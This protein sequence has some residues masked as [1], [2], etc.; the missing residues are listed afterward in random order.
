MVW[1]KAAYLLLLVM[2]A[3]LPRTDQPSA[4]H[5]IVIVLFLVV[6][7]FNLAVFH[8][9]V[10]PITSYYIKA[11]HMGTSWGIIGSSLGLCQCTFSLINMWV[12]SSSASALK[13]YSKLT[14]LFVVMAILSLGIAFWIRWRDTYDS[15]DRPFVENENDHSSDLE[16]LP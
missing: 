13:A 6:F 15:L 3:I 2:V 9:I 4:M 7:S 11:E 14:V 1:S 12:L 16:E 10:E 8:S 5:F